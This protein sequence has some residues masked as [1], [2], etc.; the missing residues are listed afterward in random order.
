[1]SVLLLVA[2]WVAAASAQPVG[3]P[4]PPSGATPAGAYQLQVS[5]GSLPQQLDQ[6]GAFS[7]SVNGP[8]FHKLH[9]E[10]ELP[11][12][13]QPEDATEEHLVYDLTGA[14]AQSFAFSVP[15]TL[16]EAGRYSVAVTARV[17]EAQE[18]RALI[19]LSV[20]E[21]SYC[22]VGVNTASDGKQTFSMTV[23]ALPVATL[24][25]LLQQLSGTPVGYEEEIGA[26]PVSGSGNYDAV[27]GPAVLA[28]G[29]GLG[30]EKAPGGGIR[31]CSVLGPS[32]QRIQP[33]NPNISPDNQGRYNLYAYNTDA[34]SL[35]DALFASAG[36]QYVVDEA[37]RTVGIQ[38]NANQ[39]T[40]EAAVAVV[41]EMAGYAYEV[42][43]GV[44]HLKPKPGGEGP[45]INLGYW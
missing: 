21:G 41:C 25:A 40:F 36:R 34:I 17:D 13:L 9:V 27:S 33:G 4:Q 14:P 10:I 22:A 32:G 5:A 42:K 44:Y 31:L 38:C 8:E 37:I 30:Y 29:M 3:P 28:L 11:L 43:D 16:R 20:Q 39:I 15:V 6:N 19:S 24:A 45:A 2:S 12:G 23:H 35:L 26:V 7:V 1:V 18:C